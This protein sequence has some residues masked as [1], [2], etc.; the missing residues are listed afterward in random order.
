M[1]RHRERIEVRGE[2]R[3]LRQLVTFSANPDIHPSSQPSPR[4]GR[5]G[6]PPLIVYSPH[7]VR[8]AGNFPRLKVFRQKLLSGHR[9]GILPAGKIYLRRSIPGQKAR[10]RFFHP[11][12]CSG[13]RELN[14]VYIHPMDAYYRYTT[15]RKCCCGDV[16]NNVPNPTSS[17]YTLP[18]VFCLS[19]TR[20]MKYRCKTRL[21]PGTLPLF[22]LY[23]ICQVF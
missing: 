9:L 15:A 22:I 23:F 3:G 18:K 12:L 7:S 19:E 2:A 8:A 4:E 17:K 5:R 6:R 14:P 1:G 11:S 16:A 10:R 13:C 20:H 21:F